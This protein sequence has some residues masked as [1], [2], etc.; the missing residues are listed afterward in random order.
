MLQAPPDRHLQIFHHLK[1]LYAEGAGE[2]YKIVDAAF[3]LNPGEI[4]EP[5]EVRKGFAIIEPIEFQPIDEKKFEEEKGDF[6]NKILSMKKMKSLEDWF[7]KASASTSLAVDL[8][9]I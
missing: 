1:C 6:R 2:S 5:I 3:K 8:D 7:K 9:M 4:S